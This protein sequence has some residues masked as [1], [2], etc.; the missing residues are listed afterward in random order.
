MSPSPVTS[1]RD[2]ILG[3]NA[4][5]VRN[6]NI[7]A[8]SLSSIVPLPSLSP[9]QN[10]RNA[11]VTVLLAHPNFTSLSV[12]LAN[13]PPSGGSSRALKHAPIS[14]HRSRASTHRIVDARRMNE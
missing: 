2:I 3:K 9:R 6:P 10:T 12:S 11:L 4:F 5:D 14:L 13:S 8:N 7:F 1:N